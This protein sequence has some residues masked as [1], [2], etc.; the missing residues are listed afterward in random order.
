MSLLDLEIQKRI[1][2]DRMASE[3]ETE[4]IITKD[5][6]KDILEEIKNFRIEAGKV[7]GV[8]EFVENMI[9]GDGS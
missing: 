5:S 7:G 1:Y 2:L 4:L 3:L 6:S 8:I 9:I